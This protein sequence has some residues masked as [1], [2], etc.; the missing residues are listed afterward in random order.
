MSHPEHR[1][2]ELIGMSV[3]DAGGTSLGRVT[4]VRLAPTASVVG[5]SAELVVEELLVARRF[6]GSLLGYDRRKDQGPWLVRSVV[7][8]LHRSSCRVPWSAVSE[9]D[10]AHSRLSVSAGACRP[11]LDPTSA[12]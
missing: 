6:T 8:R 10:W 12:T 2:S 3:E 4:D 9:V 11:L 5:G 1:L 7:Q